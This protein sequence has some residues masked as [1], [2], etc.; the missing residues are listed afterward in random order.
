MHALTDAR[1]AQVPALPRPAELLAAER[2]PRAGHWILW[3]TVA[4]VAVAIVWAAWAR[5]DIVTVGEGQVV[6]A[7][8]VQVVQNLEG[9]IVS[10]ILVSAG[11]TVVRDQ[12]L[13]RIDD[14][15]FKAQAG[16]G[17]A[18]GRAVSAR[19]ARLQA[20][21]EGR[22]FA[23]ARVLLD[24]ADDPELRRL[25][26]EEQALFERRR[27]ALESAL[28]VQRQQV[29]QRRQELQEKQ[30]RERQLEQSLALV[31]QE[32]SV[33]QPLLR[34][35]AVSEVEVLRLQRQVSDLSGELAATRA[36]L[37]R[38]QG[39]VRETEQAM[40]EVVA[41]FRA[42]AG[43]ELQQA[44]ADQA[45][46]SASNAGLDDRV[47]RTVVRAPEAGVVKQLKVNTV[48][49]VVQPGETLLEIVPA[50]DALVVEVRVS[51]AD[52]AFIAP[53]QPATVKISAYDASIYGGFPGRVEDISAD[54]L[55]PEPASERPEPYYRVR[56]RTEGRQ[57]T[58][59]SAPLP[60]LPGMTAAVDIR[61]GDRTVLQYLLKPVIKTRDTALRER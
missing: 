26:A 46:L 2:L 43:R 10:E 12:P 45:A 50:D 1:A 57:P 51:P 13:V 32:L 40:R 59:W 3:L 11:D 30:A 49:A 37:P 20:E 22:A 52:V 27:G 36:A 55:L 18:R 53:G 42:E 54:T 56:V 58:G 8:R 19:V 25:L 61:T 21:T 15:R 4:F 33:T 29:G 44:R 41:R 5:L 48:G 60:I 17:A 39:A 35:G 34:Q 6:P 31:Q 38:I 14:T 24:G 23:L 16:E 9:G 7:K 47:V 28:E